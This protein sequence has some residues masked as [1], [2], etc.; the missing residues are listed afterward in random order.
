M[1]ST[2]LQHNR[3]ILS[4]DQQF[5]EQPSIGIDNYHMFYQIVEHMITVHGCRTLNY[6]GGPSLNEENQKR[7]AA[8]CDCLN[9][10]QLPLDPRRILHMSFLNSDGEQ[11][12]QHWKQSG[13]HLPDAILC[14]NDNMALGY[15]VAAQR[16]GYYAPQDFRVSGFDNSEE[17]QIYSPP[18][19]A[20]TAAGFS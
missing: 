20:L 2:Y 7:F 5:M 3:K 15:C 17:S 12:Y 16:D 9:Q 10:Y 18:S 14:A 6:L 11:A 8:F 19:P 13:L 1:I 4:I